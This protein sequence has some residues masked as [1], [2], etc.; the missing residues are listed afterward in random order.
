MLKRVDEYVEAL[1]PAHPADPTDDELVWGGA[2]PGAGI[3]TMQGLGVG[4]DCVGYEMDEAI[5]N[6]SFFQSL[7]D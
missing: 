5:S 1:L 7:R 6:S 3:G 4:V 2:E